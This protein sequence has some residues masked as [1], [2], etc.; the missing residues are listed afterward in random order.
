MSRRITVPLAPSQNRPRPRA[1]APASGSTWTP[2]T[3]NVTADVEYA[4]KGQTQPLVEDWNPS[5]YLWNVA[6]AV[7]VEVGGG[8]PGLPA[9]PA[10]TDVPAFP[11]KVKQTCIGCH[12]QDMIVASISHRNGREE[13]G[14]DR[15]LP[16]VRT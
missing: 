8:P 3:D 2:L 16:V 13:E 5:G 11:D 7:R 1:V 12:G 14:V 4:A 6:P 10:A 15:W 9:P